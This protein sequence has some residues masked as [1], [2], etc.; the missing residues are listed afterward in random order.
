MPSNIVLWDAS[1][2]S[3]PDGRIDVRY[4]NTVNAPITAAALLDSG[5]EVADVYELTFTNNGA[6]SYSVDVVAGAGSKNPYHATGVAVVCDGSTPNK[7]IVGG[8]S[9]TCS[10]SVDTGWKAK[11]ALGAIMTSA[12]ATTDILNRGI[13]DAGTNST[14]KQIAAK[15]AGDADSATTK[16]RAVPGFYWLPLDAVAFVKKIDNHTDD[17]REH[18]AAAGTYT[19]TFANWGTDTGSGFKKADV[20]VNGNLAISTALFDGVTRYQ[21]GVTGYD[22]V[23]DRLQGLAIILA[24]T[25]ADPTSTTVTLYVR[26]GWQW[27]ELAP[28]NLGSPGTWITTD[29]TLTESGQVTGVIRTGQHADFWSRWNLPDAAAPGAIR[30]QRFSV[31]GR[32]I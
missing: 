5:Q 16:I 29:L 12:G 22:D 25:T 3:D 7:D 20:Y 26:D 14:Q 10:A 27:E 8:V 11:I 21:Y 32:T 15:N 13:I 19:I 24:N 2:L 18:M 28:D 4:E 30:L 31:R 23:N 1:N 9:I 17:T 6:G